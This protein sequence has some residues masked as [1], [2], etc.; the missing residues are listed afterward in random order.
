[1][2]ND[3]FIKSYKKVSVDLVDVDPYLEQSY[4]PTPESFFTESFNRTGGT[5]VYPPVLC[6]K[7]DG[8]RYWVLAGNGRLTTEIENG[9]QEVEVIVIEKKMTDVERATFVFD[10]NKHRV[11]DGEELYYDFNRACLLFPS[12]KRQKG[13]RYS[14]IGKELGMK[15][16]EVKE[17]VML[18]KFFQGDGNVV[19]IK[20]FNKE[21]SRNKVEKLKKI[22]EDNVEKFNDQSSFEK[23]CDSKIDYEK[24]GYAIKLLS[25][26]DNVE[27]DLMYEYITNQID[28][29]T[30][31]LKL[32]QLGKTR[33][34]IEEHNNKKS[35]TLVP[36]LTDEYK[37]NN[38]YIIKGDNF[39][40]NIENPFQKLARVIAGSPP[41]GFGE[42]RP[43]KLGEK[44]TINLN[45]EETAIKLAETYYK[46][47]HLLAEDGSIYVII[48]DF[49]MSTGEF[50]CSLEHFVIEM[51]KRGMYLVGRSVWA[52]TNP[53]SK[54]HNTTGM[55][56]GFEMVY[57]FSKM[58]SGFL[59]V[60]KMLIETEIDSLIYK[61]G[62]TN[63]KTNGETSRG[64][65]YYQSHLKKIR[66]TLS[67]QTGNDYILGNV[68]N[69]EDWFRQVE[70]E[71]QETRH[72]STTPVWLTSI[73]IAESSRI[74][75]VVIDIW[76]GVG[77]TMTSS[78]LLQRKY[79]GVEQ[80]EVFF[81]Q[82]VRRAIETEAG[83]E[84]TY[85]GESLSIN[86][87]I[88]A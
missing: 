53:L 75:D 30:F 77:N 35:N 5:Y 65:G 7:E 32:L 9:K 81:N 29:K 12:G 59:N 66:N 63:P 39:K 28:F 47:L 68:A 14:Y 20:L 27:F 83:Y 37:S 21:I 33:Q 34:N 43:E 50:A 42:K 36:I 51:A 45:G 86:K 78:L 79:I 13:D 23:L 31:E 38:T 2:N 54:S 74:G 72:T 76:N 40:V 1:M 82:S 57:R 11:K 22:V 3:Y 10:L 87:P 80:E 48:D 64:A 55:V 41:Y 52:K 8:A 73:L 19:M 46:H 6:P 25:I 15:R 60:D 18:N 88:A 69:P 16:D 62:A 49:R 71:E 85:G 44:N 56:S 67:A 84:E 17:I 70:G 4:K 58:K 61:A 24:L 26:E